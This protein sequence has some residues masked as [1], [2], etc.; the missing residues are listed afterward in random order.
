MQ[1]N[2]SFVKICK[3]LQKV[4]FTS[5]EAYLVRKFISRVCRCSI[6]QTTWIFVPTKSITVPSIIKRV[7]GTRSIKRLHS[8]NFEL[9]EE[10]SL[11]ISYHKK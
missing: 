1:I 4:N 9:I 7:S 3:W 8:F 5:F 6:K 11:E 10:D 2:T